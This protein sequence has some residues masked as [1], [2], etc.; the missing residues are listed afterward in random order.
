MKTCA[1][2]VVPEQT[3]SDRIER[4]RIFKVRVVV[5]QEWKLRRRCIG[6]IWKLNKRPPYVINNVTYNYAARPSSKP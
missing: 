4:K 2:R 1:V 3:C 6:N 5:V